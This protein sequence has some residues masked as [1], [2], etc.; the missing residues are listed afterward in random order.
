MAGF[1]SA[2]TLRVSRAARPP[3]DLIFTFVVAGRFRYIA[4]DSVLSEEGNTLSGGRLM[5]LILL[6]LGVAYYF[7]KYLLSGYK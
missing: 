6:V 7:F 1:S 5:M 4:S 2:F 3:Y